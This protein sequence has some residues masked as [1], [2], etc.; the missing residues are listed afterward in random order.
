MIELFWG[1]EWEKLRLSSHSYPFSL[2]SLALLLLFGSP[3]A[4]THL[5]SDPKRERMA[6]VLLG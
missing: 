3:E 4:T 2:H 1:V 5:L 6:S